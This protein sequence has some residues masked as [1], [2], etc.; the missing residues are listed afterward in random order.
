MNLEELLERRVMHLGYETELEVVLV[1]DALSILKTEH[2]RT[3]LA[4]LGSKDF[5]AAVVQG[6]DRRGRL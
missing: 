2:R 4:H 5:Q 3:I 6:L 1:V